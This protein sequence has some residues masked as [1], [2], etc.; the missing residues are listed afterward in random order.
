MGRFVLFLL[1]KPNGDA[2]LRNNTQPESEYSIHTLLHA[3]S[4]VE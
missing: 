2:N 3:A 4:F 1:G